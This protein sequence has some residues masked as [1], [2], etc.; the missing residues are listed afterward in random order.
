MTGYREHN[1]YASE[2]K[3]Q[4][5]PKRLADTSWYFQADSRTKAKFA[6]TKVQDGFIFDATDRC[7]GNSP[8][9]MEEARRAF[10]AITP[11]LR[12]AIAVSSIETQF[13]REMREL[14]ERTKKQLQERKA[15]LERQMAV[16]QKQAIVD[17]APDLY[18]EE[19][20]D[21]DLGEIEFTESELAAFEIR[22]PKP[23]KRK[24]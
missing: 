19:D 9:E 23:A 1:N 13:N 7:V 18:M 11:D 20:V 8:E 17:P 14:E 10:N 21:L 12:S 5:D 6:P 2:E 24:K 16:L 15:Q 4:F 3:P 22:S